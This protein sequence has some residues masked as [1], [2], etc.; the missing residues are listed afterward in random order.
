MTIQRSAEGKP[1][2]RTAMPVDVSKGVLAFSPDRK[3]YGDNT[4]LENSADLAQANLSS[5]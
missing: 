1:P 4:F 3:S 5:S 2:I